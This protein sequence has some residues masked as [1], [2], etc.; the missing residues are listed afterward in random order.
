MSHF[1]K[2]WNGIKISS[3]ARPLFSGGSSV[4]YVSYENLQHDNE[5]NLSM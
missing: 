4:L 3:K 2:H 1:I 5:L